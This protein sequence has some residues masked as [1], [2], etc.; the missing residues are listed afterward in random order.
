MTA[1][2]FSFTFLFQL[3]MLINWERDFNVIT[4]DFFFICIVYSYDKD[5][6]GIDFFGKYYETKKKA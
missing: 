2:K 5:A 1:Y 6:H 4:I 3:G